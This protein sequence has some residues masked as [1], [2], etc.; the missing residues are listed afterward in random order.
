MRKTTAILSF[1]IIIV[2]IISYLRIDKSINYIKNVQ[3]EKDYKSSGYGYSNYSAH[4]SSTQSIIEAH[5][6]DFTYSNVKQVLASYGGYKNY[7]RGLG[8]VFEKYVDFNG[9]IKRYSELREVADYVWGLYDIWGV[10]YSN[11]CGISD[12]GWWYDRYKGNAGADSAFYTSTNPSGRYGVNY[13]CYGFSNGTDLP[14]IDE[15]LGNPDK[16]YAITNCGQGVVQLLKKAGL[17][18]KNMPEPGCY[19][20]TYK[21]NGYNYT[22]IKNASS[23]KPG[24]VLYFLDKNNYSNR[25]SR[26]E[27]EDWYPGGFHT[28]IVGERNDSAGTITCYDA[29]HTYTWYGEYKH[30]HEIGDKPYDW[31]SDWIGIRYDF[32]KNLVDDYSLG[33]W[34]T[35]DK[36]K[37]FRYKDGTWPASKWEKIEGSWYYFN[38]DGYVETGMKKIDGRWYYLSEDTSNLGMMATGWKQIKGI[39]YYFSLAKTDKYVEGERYTGLN[40]VKLA[41]YYFD[42]DGKMLTGWQKIDNNWYLFDSLGAATKGWH[43]S[44]A[45]AWYYF[46]S[47]GK[48]VKGWQKLSYSGKDYWFYFSEDGTRYEGFKE[49]Q[50]LVG[51]Q[52]VKYNA[53]NYYYYFCEET[54]E[55][56]GYVK[57]AM[58]KNMTYKGYTYDSSG[59]CPD[60]TAPVLTVKYNITKNTNKDVTV[61][62]TANE[63]IQKIDGWTLSSNE[64]ILTK[65]FKENKVETIKVKDLAGNIKSIEVKITN[66]DKTAPTLTVS[67]S[68]TE[69]TSENV[70]ATITANEEI[71]EVKGWNLL[72]D[73]KGIVKTYD[74]NIEEKVVVFD[75]V[76]NQSEITVKIENIIK[77]PTIE[78]EIYEIDDY[79]IEDISPNITID[80]MLQ[81]LS[82][83]A[84]SVKYYNK[85]NEP[86]LETEKVTTGTKIVLN[87]KVE[88]ILVVT[89]DT[90]GDGDANIKDLLI[91]NKH[92]LG[93]IELKDEYFIAGD[94]NQ[95]EGIDIK[96]LLMINK[97]RLDKIEL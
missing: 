57:G 64:R 91:L 71:Q 62:I 30:T 53:K 8:G 65:T 73:R 34:K 55:P 70:I 56:E 13:G 42:N 61:T 10:D 21:S 49:G 80:E 2:L 26:T 14:G 44:K 33:T 93:K 37:W 54:G 5:K 36:G 43:E 40:T 3:K 85:N 97:Y 84:L 46:T 83:E 6:N 78:S 76:G 29:G 31:G 87:D 86:M 20:S 39:W 23:L 63:E 27:L 59:A 12:N 45:G 38:N 52:L 50:M 25:D 68:T 7:V 92:R 19:P 48:M 90:N 94:I 22:L 96:D 17:V 35:K 4:N 82:I 51:R 24:D 75:T 74:S 15:M 47:D 1:W 32:A 79:M 11:G 67:Y 9:T 41:L 81:N 88:Y 66:I 60:K 89:G 72:A 18:G 69:N 58:I 77:E 95:D 28:A 16:Y